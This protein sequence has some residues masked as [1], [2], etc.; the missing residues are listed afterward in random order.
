[1]TVMTRSWHSPFSGHLLSDACYLLITEPQTSPGM[2]LHDLPKPRRLINHSSTTKTSITRMNPQSMPPL[3]RSSS[4]SRWDS[5]SQ[6]SEPRKP[7]RETCK[8]DRWSE[9]IPDRGLMRPT[10]SDRSLSSISLSS[11][12]EPVKRPQR[13]PS[14]MMSDSFQRQNSRRSSLSSSEHS[15]GPPKRRTSVS[16][17]LLDQ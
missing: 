15:Q 3:E 6:L 7:D 2:R 11:I 17:F 9:S 10:S 16:F 5:Y 13:R 1:M 12:A 8:E 4:F 14:L